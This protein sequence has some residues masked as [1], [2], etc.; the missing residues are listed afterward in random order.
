MKKFILLIISIIILTGCSLFKDDYDYLD[1]VL[2]NYQILIDEDKFTLDDVNNLFVD[3]VS[4]ENQVLEDN[5][6]LYLNNL[7]KELIRID[8]LNKSDELYKIYSLDNIKN[9]LKD[10]KYDTYLETID[11]IRSNL[12]DLNN[13]EIY[14]KGLNDKQKEYFGKLSSANVID[15]GDYLDKLANIYNSININNDLLKILNDNSKKYS[16]SDKIIFNNRKVYNS[17]QEVM[18]KIENNYIFEKVPFALID[19]KKGPVITA[20]NASVT[21]NTTYDLASK[22]SCV[23]EVDDKVDCKINGTYDTKKIGSYKVKITAKDTSDN[24]S[25]KEITITVKAKS[26]VKKKPY[27]IEVIRNQNIVIVYGLDENNEYNKVVKVFVCSVGLGNN[28]PTGT[29]STTAGKRWGWLK[30]GVYGQYSTRIVGSI[31]FHS[32]PYFTK[33]AGDLEWEEY[34]KLGTK[35]SAGCVRM[36]VRDVKWIYDNCPVGTKVKIYDG[37]IPKGITK[38]T[39]QKI[40]ANSPNKGWDPTD[41]DPKNP[42]NK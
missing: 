23:D 4:E 39:A 12:S 27:Y 26:T 24:E 28:T 38:P 1:L 8:S 31:L 33:N 3:K 30:G 19:D 29:F 34:N 6:K 15:Y 13:N 11:N 7:S 17:Y 14:L 22:I 41:P 9:N 35:A 32:V 20:S 16:I 2:K 25:S 40:P 5:I 37:D 42:W 18:D 36:N 21:V 10:L